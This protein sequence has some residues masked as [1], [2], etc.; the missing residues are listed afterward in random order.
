MRAAGVI[1]EFNPFHGGHAYLLSR[2]R[3]AVGA[4]GC[5]VCALSGRFVQRGTPAMADPYRRAE[6]A[7]RG[8]ADLVVEL[9]FPWS[10][11]S[12]EHFAAA[13]VHILSSLGVETLAF[14]SECGDEFLLMRA[15]EAVSSADFAE[16]YATLCRRGTGTTAAYAEAVRRAVPD[17]PEGFP[18]SNDLLAL[19][20]LRA[21]VQDHRPMRPLIVRREGAGYREDTL[22][23]EGYPS[24]TALRL[25]IREAAEDP[26]A[27]AAMLAGTMPDGALEILLGAIERGEAPIGEE[28]LLPFYHAF[29]RLR[30]PGEP[31]GVAECGGG[32]SGHIARCAREAATPEEFF[33]SL[34]TKQY[35]DARLRRALL[36]GAVG[37]IADDLRVM[38]RYTTLLAASAR[39]CAY[40]GAW[41]KAHR[42]DEGFCVVTKPASAPGGRQSEMCA[43]ADGLFTLC[44]PQPQAAGGM[45]KRSPKIEQ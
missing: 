45:M 21:L 35:T 26:V 34:R 32:L 31:E 38:P 30:E 43:R 39:G 40:L 25:L 22:P 13:G 37:V 28:A 15:A 8:G 44:F 29:Y 17:A 5:V 41:Q 19:A 14:G 20:Y 33:A 6:M 23:A 16:T 2:M 7:F 36:F 18:A 9:P 42:E 10:T 24:A 12:A 3:E 27:L 11:A 4:D 1:C